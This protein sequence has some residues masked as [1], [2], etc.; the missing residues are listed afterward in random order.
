LLDIKVSRDLTIIV[1]T[2]GDRPY[3][4]LKVLRS[5]LIQ[6]ASCASSVFLRALAHSDRAA[7]LPQ[8]PDSHDGGPHRGQAAGADL[9]TFG[10]RHCKNVYKAQAEDPLKS[11]KAGWLNSALK[12]PE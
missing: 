12:P 8:L 10:C 1:P 9:L 11:D 4:R 5:R 2:W 6:G 7:A 3:R